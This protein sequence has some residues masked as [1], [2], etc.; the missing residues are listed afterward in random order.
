MS[1]EM[2]GI[3]TFRLGD[4]WEAL[5]GRTAL[6]N[7]HLTLTL[8]HPRDFWFHAAGVSGA[9]VVVRH[10][11]RPAKLHRDIKRLAAGI[12]VFFSK[13]RR[14]GTTCVH[15][16]TCESVFKRRGDAPGKVCLKRYDTVFAKPLNPEHIGGQNVDAR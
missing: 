15:W 3:R 7:D 4:Q 10:P 14:G 9:H 5:V 11:D 13:A 16:T 8:G 2:T 6:D 12:A 1:E